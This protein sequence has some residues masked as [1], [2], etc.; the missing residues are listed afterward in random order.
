MHNMARFRSEH[1]EDKCMFAFLF[2]Y[3]YARAAVARFNFLKLS[4]R[5]R[6]L[7]SQVLEIKLLQKKQQLIVETSF[8]LSITLKPTSRWRCCEAH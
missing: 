4:Q 6:P 5:C 8:S 3:H 7:S 1:S 2:Q